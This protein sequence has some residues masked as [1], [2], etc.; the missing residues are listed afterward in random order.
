[1]KLT[2][3]QIEQI[4]NRLKQPYWGIQTHLA[5]EFNVSRTTIQRIQKGEIVPEISEPNCEQDLS[6]FQR[7]YQQLKEDFAA[8][9]QNVQF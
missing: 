7:L 1:M 2:N 4:Q 6:E 8:P 5:I 3:S 9:P